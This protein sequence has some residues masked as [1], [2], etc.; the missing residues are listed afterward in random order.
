MKD[1]LL[2]TC[3]RLYLNYG[4]CPFNTQND[5]ALSRRVTE[6]VSN[7]LMRSG[8]DFAYLLPAGLDYETKRRLKEK[9]LLHPDTEQAP[10]SVLYLRMDERLSVQTALSDHAL[11]SACDESDPNAAYREAESVRALLS[12]REAIAKDEKY[13]YL[14]AHPCHAGEALTVQMLM[15]LPMMRLSRQTEKANAVLLGEKN[16]LL[17]PYGGDAKNPGGMYLIENKASMGKAA[18]ERI[19][20][21][22]QA[23]RILVSIEEN[24]R[25]T[26]KD[27]YDEAVYDPV[28]RAL[29]VGKYA[30][31][32]SVAD[33]RH[34][35][36]MLTLGVS[37]DAFEL[38]EEVLQDLWELAQGKLPSDQG[39]M[40]DPRKAD[41]LRAQRV[42]FLLNGGN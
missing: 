28:W 8:D 6:R 19:E 36:S 27:K 31:K 32:V 18:E 17:R 38:K 1:Y 29:G 24:F 42:R 35:W 15:H 16:A 4:D 21:V 12:E 5:E 20:D 3:V 23:S 34:L 11:I 25:K 10:Y 30:R 26:A 41:L 9:G 14:T 33:A 13:G 22:L 37:I 40:K 39:D 2:Q 7:A